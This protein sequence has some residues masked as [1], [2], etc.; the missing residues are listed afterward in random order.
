MEPSNMKKVLCLLF[1]LA[2][3]VICKAGDVEVLLYDLAI[4]GSLTSWQEIKVGTG[5][6]ARTGIGLASINRTIYYS[7]EFTKLESGNAWVVQAIMS[8]PKPG[9]PPPGSTTTSGAKLAIDFR[10]PGMT[11][12]L[13]RVEVRL[14]IDD[15]DAPAIA[16]FDV[17]DGIENELASLEVDFSKS[18]F[19]RHR[20]RLRWQQVVGTNYLFL[21]AE[22]SDT[23]P[24]PGTAVS[25]DPPNRVVVDMNL[26]DTEDDSA[27]T[28]VQFGNFDTA[29]TYTSQWENIHL[30]F[31]DDPTTQLPVWPRSS[32]AVPVG[33]LGVFGLVFML[34][35]FGYRRLMNTTD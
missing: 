9:T 29:G 34:A 3:P 32:V 13:Y 33:G 35:F 30:I 15:S 2:T 28:G 14:L 6:S 7:K 16:L 17:A 20:V 1:Y 4:P 22:P 25:N 11:D 10:Y 24:L 18:G 12:E 31:A 27:P 8:A 23:F 21:E 5:S 19:P 26:L